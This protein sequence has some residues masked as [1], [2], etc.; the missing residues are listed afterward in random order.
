MIR[1]PETALVDVQQLNKALT[2][3][4]TM[5]LS[6]PITYVSID[7]IIQGVR[8]ALIEEPRKEEK[9]QPSDTPQSNSSE[10][11]ETEQ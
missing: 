3:L 7:N 10:K 9:C 2:L 1:Q 6:G 4:G 5:D 11:S 8:A